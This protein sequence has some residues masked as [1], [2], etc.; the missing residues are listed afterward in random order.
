MRDHLMATLQELGLAP[1]RVADGVAVQLPSERRG[2]FVVLITPTERALAMRA[3]IMRH[4]DRAHQDVYWR[5]LTKNLTATD[6]RWAL[7]SDGDVFLTA[8]VPHSFAEADR[9]D[10]LLGGAC[11]AVDQVFEGIARTGFDIPEGQSLR[12]PPPDPS[13][14]LGAQ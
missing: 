10:G 4:P 6:W 8:Y 14:E 11:A 12:P 7:D 2:S 1:Q 3:F 13:D 9:L 5:L